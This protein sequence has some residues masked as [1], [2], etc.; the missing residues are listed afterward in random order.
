MEVPPELR[1]DIEQQL[2]GNGS[3]PSPE[4]IEDKIRP[5]CKNACI[6]SQPSCC[7]SGD[8]DEK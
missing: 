2:S 1:K 6:K 7:Y 4:L 5:L 8:Q 3:D